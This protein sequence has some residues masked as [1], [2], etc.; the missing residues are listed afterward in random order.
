MPRSIPGRDPKPDHIIWAGGLVDVSRDAAQLAAGTKQL[1]S[2]PIGALVIGVQTQC[3]VALSGGTPALK[4]GTTVA[5]GTELVAN[6]AYA[7]TA[8]STIA[9]P[10]TI[11]GFIAPLTVETPI[12]AKETGAATAGKVRLN[13]L[14][15]MAN[16]PGS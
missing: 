9:A 14:Y 7:A 15:R 4:F 16:P 12:Y 1:G 6:A 11:A 13:V 5:T 3:E 10:N 2:L 8:I